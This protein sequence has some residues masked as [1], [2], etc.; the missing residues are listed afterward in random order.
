MVFI[1][2]FTGS[3]CSLSLARPSPAAFPPLPV[4]LNS[5][6][7][8]FSLFN[9]SKRKQPGSGGR[10]AGGTGRIQPV[11]R[12]LLL[13]MCTTQ[14]WLFLKTEILFGWKIYAWRTK[15]MDLL[16]GRGLSGWAC[17]V[18]QKRPGMFSNVDAGSIC[19]VRR[20]FEQS[21]NSSF[22]ADEKQTQIQS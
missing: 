11:R 16:E 1:K 18:V 10:D 17:P 20:F 12:Q 8:L 7:D 5:P 19:S 14:I 21:I 2:L 4:H 15:N 9:Y 6:S 13:S 3:L 22:N